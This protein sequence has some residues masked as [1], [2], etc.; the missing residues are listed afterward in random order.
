M[1]ASGW[2]SRLGSLRRCACVDAHSFGELPWAC[3]HQR[4]CRYYAKMRSRPVHGFVIG[5]CYS[6]SSRRPLFRSSKKHAAIFSGYLCVAPRAHVGA[7]VQLAA[8]QSLHAL[9]LSQCQLQ[10]KHSALVKRGHKMDFCTELM[11]M[12]QLL[13]CRVS[14]PRLR[15]EQSGMTRPRGSALQ[16][17]RK[18][19]SSP[20]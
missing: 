16:L 13:C 17:G 14:A 4:V 3:A 5:I 15:K 12:E 1:S 7:I 2:P 19:V 6:A 9:S 11:I 10:S 20:Q 8:T 18:T